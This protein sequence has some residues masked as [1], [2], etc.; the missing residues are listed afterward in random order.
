M[1]WYKLWPHSLLPAGK[2]AHTRTPGRHPCKPAVTGLNPL[3]RVHSMQMH[4][5]NKQEFDSETRKYE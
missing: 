4:Y 1:T 2:V 5:Y 3:P